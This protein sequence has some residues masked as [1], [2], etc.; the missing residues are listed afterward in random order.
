[1]NKKLQIV[2]GLSALMSAS[3]P[4][5]AMDNDEAN[6]WAKAAG[7]RLQQYTKEVNELNDCLASASKSWSEVKDKTHLCML[8]HPLA[9]KLA[10]ER[11]PQ[12]LAE[13]DKAID[14]AQNSRKKLQARFDKFRLLT[15]TN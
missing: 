10:Y 8:K 12:L 3:V 2:F 5:Q 9:V 6:F 15:S 13:E 11:A 14:A 1:M 4:L 7:D